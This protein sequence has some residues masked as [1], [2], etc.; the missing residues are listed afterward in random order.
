MHDWG[1][2]VTKCMRISVLN[3]ELCVGIFSRRVNQSA[4]G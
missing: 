2:R 3:V 1:K 4:Y